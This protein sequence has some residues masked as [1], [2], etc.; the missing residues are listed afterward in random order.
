[1]QD[2]CFRY[3][4]GRQ[5]HIQYSNAQLAPGQKVKYIGN[6]TCRPTLLGLICKLYA[7]LSQAAGKDPDCRCKLFRDLRP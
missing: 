3:L 4:Y 7:T 1:M 6:A 2:R 5:A